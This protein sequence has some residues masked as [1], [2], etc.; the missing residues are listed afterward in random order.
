MTTAC[1]P[2]RSKPFEGVVRNLERRWKETDSDWAREEIGRYHV[3]NAVPA[4]K[5]NRLKPEA[6]AVKIAGQHIA[7]VA[8]LSVRE[9]HGWFQSLPADLDAKQNE[10]AVRIL[11]E[12]RERL[13]LP[14]RCG[15]RIPHLG[16]RLR[17]A[18]GRRKPAHPPC[19]ARSVWPDGRALC[20]R[21][22]FDRSAPARQRAPAC[23][24]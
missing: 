7:E 8:R 3:R 13:T 17:H 5:G 16:A 22:A 15:A 24:R 19:I 23:R 12:I 11:K 14:G 6:L 9:A 18:V 10:I 2:T 1:A 21:R 4:C 20:A